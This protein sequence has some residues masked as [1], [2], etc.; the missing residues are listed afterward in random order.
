MR[1]VSYRQETCRAVR[2]YLYYPLL[3]SMRK[4]IFIWIIV[5]LVFGVAH[6]LQKFLCLRLK[7]L[8]VLGAIVLFNFWTAQLSL[9]EPTH[10]IAM[11]GEP[12]L[13]PD[14]PHLPYANPDAPKGGTI[15]YGF[16]GSFD[17]LNPW[18]VKGRA[19]WAIRSLVY[20]PLMGRNWDEPFS[21]YGLLAE[22][23]ETSDERDWVEFTLRKEAR[24]SNGNPVTVEDVIWSFEILGT[25]GHPRYRTAWNKIE[26][27]TQTGERSVRINFNVVDREIPLIV[28]L[29][30]ILPKAE[31]EGREFDQSSL[32]LP[33][34]SGP[35]ILSDFETGRFLKFT[36]SPDYWGK[37]LSFNKGR[38]NFDEIIYEYYGDGGVVFEAFKAGEYSTYREYNAEKW[39]TQYNFPAVQNGEIVKS[40]IPNE[41]PSGIRGFVFNTRKDKFKDWQVRDALIHAFNYEF[42]NQT[43]EGGKPP[44]IT[45]YFSNSELGMRPGPATGKVKEL[46]EPFQDMLLPG[47]IEG[48]ELPTSDGTEQ[49][50][51]NIRKA[52][53]LLNAA[54]WT[55]DNEGVLRNNEGTPFEIDMVLVQGAS[56]ALA[57]ANIYE[58]A[59]Q[60]LGVRLVITIIDSAQYRER[61]NSYDFDMAYYSRGMSL[62]PG[63]EQYLY[64]GKDG[65]NT[66]GSR[67]WMGMDNPPAEEMIASMLRARKREDFVAAVRALD[68]ILTAGRYVVPI[69]FTDVSRIAHK[70][71]LTYPDV[72]PIYGDWIGFQPDVWWYQH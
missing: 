16:A 6:M 44:R 60:R 70:R 30:P 9:S 35:Y 28:G 13:G 36:R 5:I 58:Q 42:I 61:T 22:S 62:S 40:E 53:Q 3:I 29:R 64:W 54:G 46:L 19:P 68:R 39:D 20:E 2:R 12:A 59:L 21:L 69:W 14:Y 18:I 56:E 52:S 65:I 11:Y 8:L 49:N 33:V 38:H 55:V 67:N 31:W 15:E 71:E 57:I 24:F 27:I 51:R 43:L 10:G 66:P 48:Y 45:S 34:G 23:L 63:N 72:L 1:Q 37:D 47:V 7:P 41:R 4:C 32:D 25:K 50:R 26:S 17:S